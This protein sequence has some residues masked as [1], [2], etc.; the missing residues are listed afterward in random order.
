MGDLEGFKYSR[1]TAWPKADAVNETIT[2][3]ASTGALS[4]GPAAI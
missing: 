1:T 2:A 3:N 4:F